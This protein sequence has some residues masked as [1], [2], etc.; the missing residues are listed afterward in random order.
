MISTVRE[1]GCLVSKEK[2]PDDSLSNNQDQQQD[3]KILFISIDI[4]PANINITDNTIN[5]ITDIH[6]ADAPFLIEIEDFDKQKEKDHYLF[7]ENGTKGRQ[8]APIAQLTETNKTFNKKIKAWFDNKDIKKWLNT[9]N[10]NEQKYFF[11]SVNII[12]EK[13]N[14]NI[15]DSIDKKIKE[16]SVNK[17]NKFFISVKINQRYLGDYKIFKKIVEYL[18]EKK[19]EESSSK[20]QICAVCGQQTPQ[21]SGKTNIYKFY[22]IDKPGFIVGGFQESNAWKNFPVCSDCV[23]YLR[24]GKEYI[25]SNLSFKFYG[26]NYYLIPQ[27]IINNENQIPDIYEAL[28]DSQKIIKLKRATK[29][30]ITDNDEE[31]LEILSNEKNSLTLN[32][33]FLEKTKSAEKILLLI[34]DV[35]PSRIKKIFGA[36]DYVDKIFKDNQNEYNNNYNNDY[37]FGK[38]RKFYLKSDNNKS[39]TDLDKYFLDIINSVFKGI[40]IDFLFALSFFIKGIRESFVNQKENEQYFNNFNSKVQAALMN[41]LFF[42]NIGLINFREENMGSDFF[43]GFFEKY[44]KTFANPTKRGIFLLGSL[45]QLLLDEQYDAR[46]SK[47]FIKKLKGL[48][49]DDR[50][51]KALL[52][53]VQNKLEEYGVFEDNKN[54]NL[55]YQIR[56]DVS[57]YLLLNDFDN[58]GLSIDEINFYFACGMNLYKNIKEYF[59]QQKQKCKEEL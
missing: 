51:I 10:T 40:K 43:G 41:I 8:T 7:N 11:N 37:D 32:F 4:N 18:T 34:E 16:F 57:Q 35:F 26:L 39:K 1:I 27:L 6:T 31:I 17:K 42:E 49:M 13:Y 23:S 15:I 58:W 50:D 2:I 3:K 29:K 19:L 12:L 30:K 45:T 9:I 33:L 22:T 54:R 52:P 36:K 44:V 5:N 53:D 56:S 48:R 47:P 20:N 28:L 55:A 25:E 24:K 38:L 59:F 46:G 14:K 21:V